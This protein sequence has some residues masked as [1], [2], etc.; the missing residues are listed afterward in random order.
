MVTKLVGKG[1]GQE[2]GDCDIGHLG[3]RQEKRKTQEL[4]GGRLIRQ[5]CLLGLILCLT[6]A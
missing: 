5:E 4:H 6:A 3:Y 1:E 2:D